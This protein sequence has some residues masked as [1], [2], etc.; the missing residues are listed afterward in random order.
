MNRLTRE[1]LIL[2][3]ADRVRLINILKESLEEREDDNSRF[4]V[5]LKAATEVCGEGILSQSRDFNL[6]MGRRL[7]AYQMRKEGY[8]FMAIGRRMAKHH[9]SVIHMV[10]MMEDVINY[11]FKEIQYWD[12]FQKKLKEYETDI[13]TAQES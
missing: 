1:C 6:V 5:L 7:I 10:Q 4:Q 2:P 9:A 3:K 12:A 8:S 13:R 11:R